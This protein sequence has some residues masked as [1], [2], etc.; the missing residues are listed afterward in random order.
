MLI[1]RPNHL[2]SVLSLLS[3]CVLVLPGTGC[4][5]DELDV[6]EE[7]PADVDFRL[8][9]ACRL[10]D[11]PRATPGG[12]GGRPSRGRVASAWAMTPPP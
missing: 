5:V 8:D 2:V 11:L 3:L 4:E 10:A 9:A 6:F 7:E 1:N 12:A